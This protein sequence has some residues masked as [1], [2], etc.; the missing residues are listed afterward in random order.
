ML[1]FSKTGLRGDCPSLLWYHHIIGNPL[2]LA[3]WSIEEEVLD[4]YNLSQPT[5]STPPT[6]TYPNGAATSEGGVSFDYFLRKLLEE[7]RENLADSQ[8]KKS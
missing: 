5:N 7:R 1:H 3:N 2:V 8:D 4:R 6:D